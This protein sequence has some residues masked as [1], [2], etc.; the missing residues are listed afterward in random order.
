M[1]KN[2]KKPDADYEVGFCKPP[3][4]KQFKKGESG[5]PKG[6]PK[7]SV[8]LASQLENA[9]NEKVEVREGDRVR[10]M[11]K[12][13]VMIQSLLGRAMKGD[14]QAMSTLFRLMKE[15][16]QTR[17]PEEAPRQGKMVAYPIPMPTP[18]LEA[19]AEEYEYPTD[20]T[21]PDYFDMNS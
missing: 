11:T 2:T 3:K 4:S 7:G 21:A 9:L 14:Q 5:N 17:P 19:L 12:G 6:R 13:E 8:S 1:S 18:L 10:K 20:H 15:T 16:G